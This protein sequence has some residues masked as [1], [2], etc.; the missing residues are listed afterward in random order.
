[1]RTAL[2]H[3]ATAWG[4]LAAAAGLNLFWMLVAVTVFAGQFRAARI[5]GAL[6]S[7]GE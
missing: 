2:L 6:I 5:R 1:M 4:Q 3:G 7:I